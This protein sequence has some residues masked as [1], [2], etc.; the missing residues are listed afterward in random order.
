[1]YS[2]GWLSPILN[3]CSPVANSPSLSPPAEARHLR[4]LT[5]GMLALLARCRAIR[6]TLAALAAELLR[7]RPIVLESLIRVLNLPSVAT[8]DHAAA[9][10]QKPVLP[11]EL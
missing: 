4:C 2:P 6:S 10:P 5:L 1:M 3:R 11:V 7:Q 9:A 8:H